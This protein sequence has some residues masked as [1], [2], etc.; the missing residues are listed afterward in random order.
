MN[1]YGLQDSF[2]RAKQLIDVAE[3]MQVI[4]TDF[5][6]NGGWRT[7]D[8]EK[9]ALYVKVGV[10]LDKYDAAYGTWG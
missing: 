9:D 10:A 8:D 1:K 2:D 5:Y 3:E 7:T 6:V 4:L